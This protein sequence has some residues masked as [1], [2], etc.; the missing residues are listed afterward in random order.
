MGAVGSGNR[1]MVHLLLNAKAK[2][3]YQSPQDGWT[4]LMLAARVGDP[5]IVSGLLRRGAN[6][7]L[8]NRE[9]QTAAD[10]A[11]ETGNTKA[12]KQLQ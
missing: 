11:K 4:A 9:D 1:I 5:Q 7:H 10:I 6:P 2:V 8:K 12:L 3:N